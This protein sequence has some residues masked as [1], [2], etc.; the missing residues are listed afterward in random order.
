L[1]SLGGSRSFRAVRSLSLSLSLDE[2]LDELEPD[3]YQQ[4]RK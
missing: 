4:Q 1:R 2:E 3:M